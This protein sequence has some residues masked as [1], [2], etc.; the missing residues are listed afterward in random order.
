M[1]RVAHVPV[2]QG[3]VITQ[4]MINKLK[5]GMTRRQVSYVMGDPV[6]RDSFNPDRWDYVHSYQIGNMAYQ[7]LRVSLFFN[8]DLLVSFSGD[9]AP[10][11]PA[12]AEPKGDSEFNSPENDPVINDD[13]DF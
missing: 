7:E 2:Q 5:P 11:L 12:T 10:N 9:L 6:M 1:P 13:P 4:E 3:N 8:D